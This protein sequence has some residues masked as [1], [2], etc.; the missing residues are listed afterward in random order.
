MQKADG[1]EQVRL[2]DAVGSGNAGEGPEADIDIEQVL[3][4]THS[5]TS[6][7]G[8]PSLVQRE[9]TATMLFRPL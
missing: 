2:A 1:I 9:W 3:E 5:Q 7:H 6:Q 4:A 8:T